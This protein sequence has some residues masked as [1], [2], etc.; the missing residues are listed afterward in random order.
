MKPRVIIFITSFHPFIGGAE[1]AVQETIKRLSSQFDFFILTA[2]FRHN[3]PKKEML[4]NST[5]YRLGFGIRFDKWLFVVFAPF[6]F[7][8][9]IVWKLEI[10][11]WKFRK[12]AGFLLWGIDISQGSLAAALVKL[13]VPRIPFV[14]TIQYGDGEKRLASGRRGMLRNTFRFMLRRADHVTAISN[15]LAGIARDYG[16]CGPLAVVPNGVD[17]EKFKNQKQKTFESRSAFL[18][19]SPRRRGS[20]L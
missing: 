5:V 13:A 8:Y 2:R 19:S 11:N 17:A 3:L 14:V 7:F 6:Y 12:P 20:S 1:I 15:H 18:L 9:L 16:Y 4:F 10:G